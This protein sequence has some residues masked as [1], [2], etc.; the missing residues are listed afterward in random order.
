MNKHHR[1]C[2]RLCADAGLEVLNFEHRGRHLALHT[3]K[4]FL[5]APCTPGDRR[6]RMNMRAQARRLAKT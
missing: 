6:W 4:G 5:S 3:N 1:D 2:L